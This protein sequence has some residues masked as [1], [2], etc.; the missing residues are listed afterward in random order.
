MSLETALRKIMT[1]FVAASAPGA[2]HEATLVARD[3]WDLRVRCDLPVVPGLTIRSLTADDAGALARFGGSL[4]PASKRLFCPYPWDDAPALP[5]A[6]EH[7]V[8]QAVRHVDAS[9]LM[10]AGGSNPIGHFFLWKAG[11]NPTS[12]RHE[13]QVP[14]LGVAIADA[15]QARGLGRLAVRILLAVAADLHADAV[16]LTTATDNSAGW[17]TY[18]RCGFEYTGILRIPLGV[19]VTAV[20]AGEV[21]AATFRDQAVLDY[22]ARKRA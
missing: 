8:Q 11:A 9:Y 7:A 19:D 2:G 12:L 10:E 14:E 4:G 15:W 16:E 21:S 1:E 17:S 13:V 6:F 18:Q 3:A 5:A 22:L 20:D